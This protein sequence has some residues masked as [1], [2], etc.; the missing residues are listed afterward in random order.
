MDVLEAATIPMIAGNSESALENLA[1]DATTQILALGRAQNTQPADLG[2]SL[3]SIFYIKI[4]K[5]L[6][7]ISNR[8]LGLHS[9]GKISE[10][11][12][13]QRVVPVCYC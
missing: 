5:L 2:I 6:F 3:T 10:H 12:N 4:V 11:S 13:R 9:R 8:S 7:R 1:E